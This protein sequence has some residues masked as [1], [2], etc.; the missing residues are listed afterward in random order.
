[1][2]QSSGHI[3]VLRGRADRMGEDTQDAIVQDQH[4]LGQSD[5][6][7][8]TTQADGPQ[9]HGSTT[10]T[11]P[12]REA[13]PPRMPLCSHCNYERA[14]RQ[15]GVCDDW[16]CSAHLP[17][18]AHWCF[19]PEDQWIRECYGRG[20]PGHEGTPNNQEG[21][22]RISRCRICERWEELDYCRMCGLRSCSSCWR[23]HGRIGCPGRPAAW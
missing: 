9:D 20:Q 18:P 11:A 15:C 2:R 14:N 8:R 13:P 16:F 7:V 3:T 6:T 23:A 1:M 19:E 17:R 4:H 12:P 21:W 22:P 10:T 5:E